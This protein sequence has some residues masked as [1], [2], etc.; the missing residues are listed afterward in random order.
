MAVE[1]F[2][3][4][5]PEDLVARIEGLAAEE[6]V[7]RSEII[8]EATARY[9]ASVDGAIAETRRHASVNAAV[10]S[11]EAIAAEWGDD[12]IPGLAYLDELRGEAAE[13]RA[14]EGTDDE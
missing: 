8:R 10:A 1:K 6:G 13:P 2:S 7:S 14:P 11:F 12:E 9:V 4:S 5:L 3:V